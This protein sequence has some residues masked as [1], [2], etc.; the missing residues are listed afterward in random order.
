MLGYCSTGSE[1]KVTNPATMMSK[2]STV[3]KMGRSI[4][5]FENISV[6]FY[7]LER[8]KR[9][10]K[11]DN[12]FARPSDRELKAKCS[13]DVNVIHSQTI[14]LY[15]LL[16]PFIYFSLHLNYFAFTSTGSTFIPWRTFIK[17]LVTYRSSGESPEVTMRIPPS[18]NWPSSMCR[19]LTTLLSFTT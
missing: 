10:L 19:V 3:A 18:T 15:L 17:A 11:G 1:P 4:K 5:N 2:A 6:W 12:R 16:S 8:S 14:G 9:E 13:V 7:F